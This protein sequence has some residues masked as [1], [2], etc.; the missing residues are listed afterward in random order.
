M[1]EIKVNHFA[2][3]TIGIGTTVEWETIVMELFIV[4]LLGVFAYIGYVASIA[5]LLFPCALGSVACF[6][7]SLQ[8]IY[9]MIMDSRNS[10]A[11]DEQS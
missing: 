9:L 8:T 6:L 5:L 1:A 4:F 7:S 3:K 2:A 10:K 11:Q